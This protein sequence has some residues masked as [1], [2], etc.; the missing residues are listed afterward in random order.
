MSQKPFISII[1]PVHNAENFLDDCLQS[2]ISQLF[3]DWELIIVNDYSTD[4]SNSL[5]IEWCKKDERIQLLQNTSKGII[6]A[7]QLAFEHSK[8]KYITRMDADDLMP[9]EKL[10]LFAKQA[11]LNPNSVVTGKVSYFS[12]KSVSQGYLR[13]E[14]WLN[15]L[16]DQKETFDNRRT[17]HWKAV[18]RECVIAS[19]N[20]LVKRSCF[21]E[22]FAFSDLTYPEDYDMVFKWYE[23]GYD[24]AVINE[25]TH[26][27][28][29][30][31]A[32]TSRNSEN[33][34]QKAFFNL[35]TERFIKLELDSSEKIQLIGAGIK[36]K[37]VAKELDK[38]KIVY[39]WFDFSAN[40]KN[41]DTNGIAIQEL[42]NV[43]A[44]LK[45]ILTV[46][47]ENEQLKEQVVNFL[48]EKEL[49]FG[50]NCWLF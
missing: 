11:Q 21:E 31:P 46:W 35:K 1:M 4:T 40:K 45:T 43:K 20:W 17:A 25:I 13:Y 29:E 44:G 7:L 22:D 16:I 37:L 48:N 15:T 33:Y 23:K 38:H 18:Y 32:R 28:R 9:R 5:L 6:P 36:G 12:E 8:G 26:L 39:D 24:I 19:P 34:Q 27:W 2:I 41:L 30:H 3:I 14:A 10:Q 42:A 47:P 50:E 49:V